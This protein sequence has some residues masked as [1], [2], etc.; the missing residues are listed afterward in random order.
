M[1]RFCFIILSAITIFTFLSAQQAQVTNVVAAQRTDGSKI[2]DITYDLM[3]DAVFGSYTVTV[4]ISLDNGITFTPSLFVSGEVG[5]GILPEQGKHI[6]WNLA[7]EYGSI[8]NENMKVRVIA[9]GYFTENP[10]FEFVLVP[11]GEFT[12]G[13]NNEIQNIDYDFEI[14]KYEVTY[15]QYVE[16]LISERAAGNI[17]HESFG[18]GGNYAVYGFY[19]GDQNN[20]SGNY[21]L[22]IL[23]NPLSWNGTTYIVEEG[24]GDHPC[25]DISYIGAY[26]FAYY[27]GMSIPSEQ[28]WEKAA[29]GNTGY[30]YPWGNDIDGNR[31][32]YSYSGDPWDNGTTPVGFYNGQEYLGFQTTD[33][34]SP[35]GAYDMAGNAYEWTSSWYSGDPII[36]GGGWTTQNLEIL[37]SWYS[38]PYENDIGSLWKMGFRCIKILE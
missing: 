30:N 36:R 23:F 7:D 31:A 9:T 38:T 20:E 26:L 37:S 35:F 28:E 29:R 34:P 5:I 32:N 17:W 10:P 16:Y 4:K 1:Q 18:F 19:P 13:S 24:F 15:A 12:Y 21:L 11:A 6:V 25:I 8:F 33:S 2:V 22:C 27:Y 14:M 3:E